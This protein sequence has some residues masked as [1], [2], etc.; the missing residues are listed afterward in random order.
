MYNNITFDYKG[1]INY[2]NIG[3]D[4][5]YPLSIILCKQVIENTINIKLCKIVQS[6]NIITSNTTINITGGGSLIHPNQ[7]NF[8]NFTKNNNSY[9]LLG[10]GMTDQKMSNI[11]SSNFNELVNNINSFSFENEN[12]KCNLNYL[13]Y[14]QDNNNLFGGF[15]GIYEETICTKNGYKFNHINDIGLFPEILLKETELV[16]HVYN[17]KDEYININNDRKIILIN[18]CNIFGIDC[19][20]DN[21]ITYEKY[22]NNI[23][24]I[25]IKFGIFLIK[26]G[27]S[28][29]IMPF[30]QSSKKELHITEYVYKSIQN[31]IELSENKFL[32]KITKYNLISAL[33]LF[34]KV[35]IAIGI[36]LHCNII[37][38]GFLIPTINIAYGVKGVNYSVTNNLSKYIIPTFF[39]YLSY[40]KLKQVFQDIEKNYDNI[41]DLLKNNKEKTKTIIYN[42]IEKMFHNYDLS[43]YNN[44]D[45]ILNKTDQYS[46]GTKF[47]FNFYH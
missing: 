42:E 11:N 36:R 31:N 25:F 43:K 2:G 33:N 46:R 22:N 29:V 1:L 10:T 40:D 39:K 34:K 5:F 30:H 4:I 8:T 6:K 47:H 7:T 12:I 3:D 16:K 41:K 13:K 23:A 37:C 45:I 24:D 9:L 19:F 27:Y 28:V 20:K 14:F 44:F 17:I 15:R 18:T 38:N 21:C 26:N 35:Y 32:M